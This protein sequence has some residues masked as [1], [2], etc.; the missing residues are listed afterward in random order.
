[1]VT[2]T[3]AQSCRGSV[4]KLGSPEIIFTYVQIKYLCCKVEKVRIVD[5]VL[6]FSSPQN[7]EYQVKKLLLKGGVL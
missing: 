2:K 1:M 5:R 3:Q 7:L 4:M 6:N